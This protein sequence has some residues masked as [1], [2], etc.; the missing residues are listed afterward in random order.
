MRRRIAV[1][2]SAA[3]CSFLT[4]APLSAET[5]EISGA[6]L[7]PSLVPEAKP[8]P[9]LFLEA[10]A[11]EPAAHLSA[12]RITAAAEI[13]AIANWNAGGRQPQKAGFVRLLERPLSVELGGVAARSWNGPESHGLLQVSPEEGLTWATRIEVD[14]SSRLRLR[15]ESVDLP[16]DVEMLIYDESGEAV[17]FGL[18]LRDADGGMW[19]PSIAGPVAFLEL[20]GGP[21]FSAGRFE[22]TAVAEEFDL[23]EAGR[24]LL[25]IHPKLITSCLIASSCVSTGVF[26]NIAV[27]QAAVAHIRYIK[28]GGTYICSGGLL[29]D[30]DD[31][32]YIPY[33]LTANHCFSNQGSASSLEAFWDYRETSCGGPV[34]SLGSLPRSNGSTLLATSAN[35]DFTFVRLNSLPGSR[36]LLGWTTTAPGNGS[37]AYSVHHPQGWQQAYSRTVLDTTPARVCNGAP[38]SRFIYSNRVDGT[39][40]PGSSGAPLTNANTQVIGQL[41]GGCADNTAEPCLFDSNDYVVYGRFSETYNSISSWLNRTG[42]TPGQPCVDNATTLC[43]L[44]NRFKVQATYRTSSGQTGEAKAVRLTQETGYFWFFNQSNIEAVFKLLDGCG[45]NSRYWVFAGGLTDV[46]VTTTITDT[47]SG[48]TRTFFNPLNTPFQP[49]ADTSAFATCP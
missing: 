46:E 28:D 36:Y 11:L 6:F 33:F 48:A 9:R 35:S 22:I 41:L 20:R 49:I 24:P 17:R 45:L 38:T 37:S 21:A 23:D 29:N 30:R 3:L 42:G 12:A 7:P 44:N 13:E 27:L 15:I 10:G 26:S 2:A 31:S 1:L 14:E 40:M 25:G 4:V 18:E 34:P 19:T 47:R 8:V 32:G 5:A 16:E 43:L 39:S